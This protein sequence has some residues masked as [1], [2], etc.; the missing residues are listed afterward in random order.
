M[1]TDN[2]TNLQIAELL[3]KQTYDER[4]EMA[5]WFRDVAADAETDGRD[6]DHYLFGFWLG[7]WAEQEIDGYEAIE[8]QP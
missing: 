4:M 3:K 7:E 5:Q 2:P 8:A 6:L 1:G